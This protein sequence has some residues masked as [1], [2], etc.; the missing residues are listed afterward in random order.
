MLKPKPSQGIFIFILNFVV[1]LRTLRSPSP[2]QSTHSIAFQ[3]LF[4]PFLV[5]I[6]PHKQLAPWLR[7]DR[8]EDQVVEQRAKF[9]LNIRHAP[10]EEPVLSPPPP[11]S[12]AH[13]NEGTSI[14]MDCHHVVIDFNFLNVKVLG[15]RES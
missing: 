7:W 1:K 4:N 3:I 8:G 5:T 6:A 2:L 15:L 11:S 10:K 13:T 9:R 12:T 14:L